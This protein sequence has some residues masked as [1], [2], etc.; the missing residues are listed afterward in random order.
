MT[1]K[2]Y[3]PDNRPIVR[4][5]GA[6]NQSGSDR[7]RPMNLWEAFEGAKRGGYKGWWFLPSLD[8]SRQMPQMTRIE[9]ARKSVW[10][11]NNIGE[12][13]ALIDGLAIDEVDTGLWPKAMT[14]NPAFNKA[15]TNR[16]HQENYDPRSFDLRGVDD[17]YSAQFLIRRTVRLIGDMFAQLVRPF[18]DIFGR[19][20]PRL[21]F[22]PGYQCTSDGDP[23]TN[24]L[25][26][27]IRFDPQTG[28]ALKFRF[29]LPNYA[30]GSMGYMPEAQKYI[31]LDSSDVLHFHDP[32][33]G[34]QIRGVSA[35]APVTKDMFSMD[36]IDRHETTGQTLRSKIAYA[37]ETIGSDEAQIPRLPGV[38]DVEVIENPDGSKT[39][40]Q[41]VVSRD[42]D[43]FDVFTPP[44][45]MRLK[46]VE[47]N[48]GGAID[49][50][51]FLARKMVHATI[52][53]PEWALF[54]SG[55]S[56]GT[57]TRVVQFRVQKIAT[58]FR[59]N[60][61]SSQFLKRDYEFWLWQRIKTGTFDNVEG[62]VPDDWFIHRV[63]YPRDLSVDLAREGKL[64]DDRVMRGN[65]S[66]I[67]YHAE[68][69]RDNEDVDEELV[70]MAI[71]RRLLLEEKLKAHPELDIKYEQI[72]RLPPGT[73]NAAATFETGDTPAT[74]T[75]SGSTS[76]NNG[77]PANRLNGNGAHTRK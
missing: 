75:A 49:F 11:Y 48:R 41:K 42:G 76:G 12:V 38:V 45:N 35:L 67:D 26:Q 33:L 23:E 52:Y 14:S 62:G 8:T 5:P 66:D 19:L 72:W 58:F 27:G 60:Q 77:A 15:V 18:L 10:C 1:A 31:E 63:I 61:I 54:I 4:L 24:T 37:I 6:G 28:A 57:V 34:D 51:N 3:G 9:L 44:A 7:P 50:R 40:I 36:D 2:L 70:D 21:G 47:S 30:A 68:G 39:V 64:K 13:R 53:P 46:T 59:N 20:T 22:L 56:Q 74:A 32:F 69:G 73:A 71:R 17:V 55:L 29:A 43:E 16:F 65:M 25:R